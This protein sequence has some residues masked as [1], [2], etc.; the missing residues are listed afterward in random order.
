MPNLYFLN[1]ILQG[2][3]AG[4]DGNNDNTVLLLFNMLK[5]IEKQKPEH[6]YQCVS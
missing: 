3:N 2:N 5:D 4:L 6:N 1:N